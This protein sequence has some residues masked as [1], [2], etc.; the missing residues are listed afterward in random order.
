M[1]P[2][3]SSS[4]PLLYGA[5]IKGK[6][7]EA[8]YYGVPVITTSIGA[9]GLCGTEAVVVVDDAAAFAEKVVAY[10]EDVARFEPLSKAAREF[11]Q[12]HFTSKSVLRVVG[13]DFGLG[14]DC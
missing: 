13:D 12:E 14:K 8:L 3:A 6:V 9:E 5:G 10:H 2:V 11:V 4:P 1:A 7:V